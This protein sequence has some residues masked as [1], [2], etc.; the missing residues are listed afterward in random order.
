MAPVGEAQRDADRHRPAATDDPAPPRRRLGS[1]LGCVLLSIVLAALLEAAR[2]PAGLLLGPMI[3]AIL[4]AARDRPMPVPPLVGGAG[5]AIV[6]VLIA[7]AFTRD[8]VRTVADR[9]LLFLATTVAT[10]GASTAIGLFLT[11][12]QVLPGTVAVWG[13]MPGAATAMTLLAREHGADPAL[14]AVMSFGRVVLVAALASVLAALFGGS[15]GAGACWFPP[16]EFPG[17]AATVIAAAVGGAIG[18]RLL[19]AGALLGPMLLGAGLSLAFGVRF[20]LP[21]WLLAPAYA[22]VGWGIGRGFTRETLAAARIALPR[23]LLATGALILFC[24]ALAPVVAWWGQVDLLSAYLATSPGGMD[25]VAIIAS[26]TRV[27]LPFVMAMQALRFAAVLA[28]GPPIARWA[29]Y[30]SGR[31]HP[32][33]PG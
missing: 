20:A 12:R 31:M 10:L 28:L 7:T 3:A 32:V 26:E 15:G 1:I 29:A 11:K 6:G 13:S 19:P 17:L 22:V 27:A 23:L 33:Q 30:R 8:L 16:L 24:A 25:S 9:P 21:G 14:V 5:Q 18:R 2:L 4:F